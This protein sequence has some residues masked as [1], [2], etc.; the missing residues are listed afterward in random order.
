MIPYYGSDA[1]P[2]SSARMPETMWSVVLRAK[3][4]SAHSPDEALSRLCQTYWRPLYAF[5]RRRGNSPHQAEDFTQGFF[6]HLFQRDWLKDVSPEKGRFRTYLLCCLTNYLNNQHRSASGPQ[7]S[8]PGGMVSLD[9]DFEESSLWQSARELEPDKAFE[10]LWVA[11]LIDHAKK[12]LHSEHLSSGKLL[13]FEKLEPHLTDRVE[14]GEIPGIASSLGMTE[15]AARGAL[16]RL[17]HRFGKHLR[18]IVP[19][20]SITPPPSRLTPKSAHSSAP[21]ASA[22]AA[23]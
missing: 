9:P 5:V 1:Q 12:R 4:D 17:R 7:R 19:T 8:P 23:A 21:G 6:G 10:R 13:L 18:E 20:L 22:N 3:K 14:G 11:E 15:E 16:K 2:R